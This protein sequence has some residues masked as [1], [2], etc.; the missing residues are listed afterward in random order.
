M[1]SDYT[2][3]NGLR[4]K[5]L[6][7]LTLAHFIELRQAANIRTNFAIVRVNFQVL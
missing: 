3:I 5:L 2:D 1:Q 7:A 6:W 4:L